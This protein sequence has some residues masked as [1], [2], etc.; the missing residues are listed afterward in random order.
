MITQTQTLTHS[1]SKLFRADERN[2]TETNEYLRY[3]TCLCA[4]AT[5]LLKPLA[6]L[7]AV[8]EEVLESGQHTALKAREAAHI[9]LIPL[10]GAVTVSGQQGKATVRAGE[11]QLYA[12]PAAGAIRFD[13]PCELEPV[14]FLHIWLNAEPFSTAGSP[15]SFAFDLAATDNQL[16]Q[17]VPASAV[18]N[19]S[20]NFALSLGR[21]EGHQRIGYQL[22][23]PDSL[24]FAFVLWVPSKPKAACSMSAIASPYGIPQA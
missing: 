2:L 24:F 7:Q 13:N 23:N 12:V 19:L 11:V 5:T 9:L 3:S 18:E 16:Q 8:H 1:G 14:N 10:I 17:V 21:F 15:Q 22:M 20:A 6:R 4:G